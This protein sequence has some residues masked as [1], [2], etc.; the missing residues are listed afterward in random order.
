MRHPRV[1]VENGT[2]HAIA[3]INRGEFVFQSE[4]AREL[5]IRTLQ[6]AKKR[7]QFRIT[8]M[9]IMSNH[10][11]IMITPD[12]GEDLS[13]IMQWLLGTFAVRYNRLIRSHGHVWGDRFKS[14]VVNGLRQYLATFHYIET[15]P[16]RAGIVDQAEEYPYGG[17]AF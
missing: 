17:L 5:F 16:V 8:S 3:R 6:Q 14:K 11:H 1:K 4:K 10:V 2:Y 9:C 7:H 15:N 13:V 12:R